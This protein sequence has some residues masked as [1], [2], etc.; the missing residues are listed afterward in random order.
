M[1]DWKY[2]VMAALRTTGVEKMAGHCQQLSFYY[3]E[4]FG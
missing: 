4:N 3:A 1:E 2:H